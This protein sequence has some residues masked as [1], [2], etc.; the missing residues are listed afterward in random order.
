MNAHANSPVPSAKPLLD[1]VVTPADLRKLPES[2]LRQLAT[3]LRE[4]MI[5][6]VSVTNH[7]GFA[8]GVQ[9]HPEWRAGEN[10]IS[11]RLFAAFGDACR[12]RHG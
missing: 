3:E 6:A 9:W 5:E 12:A 4:E 11:R 2:D 10:E 8:V 7:S 1:Q